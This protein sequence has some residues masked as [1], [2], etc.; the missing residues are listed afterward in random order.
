MQGLRLIPGGAA[1]VEHMPPILL[2]FNVN[3]WTSAATA[4][5]S[6][7]GMRRHR[8]RRRHHDGLLAPRRIY[9][10]M[11]KANPVVMESS[12]YGLPVN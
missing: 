9:T 4:P 1:P 11:D 12:T 7:M 6:A 3:A 10:A 8:D 5:S 2:C